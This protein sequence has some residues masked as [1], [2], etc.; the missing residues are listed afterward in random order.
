MRPGLSRKTLCASALSGSDLQE[1]G[2]LLDDVGS[3]L[4]C[5]VV[6]QVHH[7]VQIAAGLFHLL[8]TEVLV[9]PDC[10]DLGD[11]SPPTVIHCFGCHGLPGFLST[12]ATNV[13][14]RNHTGQVSPE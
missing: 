1:R 6:N 8:V 11:Y 14:Y 10:L 5:L 4:T 7:L 13:L 12:L 2:D 9:T 3:R